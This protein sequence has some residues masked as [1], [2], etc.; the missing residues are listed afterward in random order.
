MYCTVLYCTVLYGHIRER[1]DCVIPALI[2]ASGCFVS[3]LGVSNPISM[4]SWDGCLEL[5]PAFLLCVCYWEEL[6]PGGF[7]IV[8][9]AAPARADHPL[10]VLGQAALPAEGGVGPHNLSRPDHRP[11][12]LHQLFQHFPLVLGEVDSLIRVLVQ[13]KQVEQVRGGRLVHRLGVR[14]SRS[15]PDTQ[16]TTY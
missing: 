6:Q 8:A 3:R 2:L 11:H 15:L 9:G 4:P 14:L 5:P 13:V 12:F 7:L 1:R 10:P 16:I